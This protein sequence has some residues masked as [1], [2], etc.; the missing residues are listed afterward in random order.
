MEV[1]LMRVDELIEY[2]YNAKSH[3]ENG[4]RKLTKKEQTI[5]ERVKRTWYNRDNK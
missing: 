3:H 5:V 4:D 1:E 2:R